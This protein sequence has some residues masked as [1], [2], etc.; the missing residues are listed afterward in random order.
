MSRKRFD[1][2]LLDTHDR[3][4]KNFVIKWLPLL[5]SNEYKNLFLCENGDK[6]G[7]D[8]VGIDDDKRLVGVEVEHKLDGGWVEEFPYD[9]VRIPERKKKFITGDREIWFVVVNKGFTRLCLIPSGNIPDGYVIVNNRYA[10]REKFFAVPIGSCRWFWIR[11]ED[12]QEEKVDSGSNQEQGS[13]PQTIGDSGGRED[14]GFQ[15]E[16]GCPE[17]WQIRQEGQVSPDPQENE[18][19]KEVN[20][21]QENGLRS[22]S[23]ADGQE[24]STEES[25]VETAEG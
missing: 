10:K 19:R 11:E 4:T 20:A 8:L 14:S 25:Q 6:Y 24:S 7:I 2:K 16:R 5:L 12:G 9:C 22:W 13:T 23:E 17:G 15:A 18:E 1:Q 3:I 21:D